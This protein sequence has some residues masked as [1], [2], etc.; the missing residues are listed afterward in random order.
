MVVGD[1]TGRGMEMMNPLVN[2]VFPEF[3]QLHYFIN[4]RFDE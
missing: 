2:I 1:V 4:D 3:W